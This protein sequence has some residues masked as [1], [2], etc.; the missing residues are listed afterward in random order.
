MNVW[1]L[2]AASNLVKSEEDPHPAEGRR[3]IRV[4]KV[5]V[6]RED[7]ALFCGKRKI[8][9]PLVP[10]RFAVG[11]VADEG[12]SP[13]FPKGARVLLHSR[14]PAEDT[15]AEPRT[16]TE[17]DFLVCGR[18]AD[19]FLRDFVYAREEDLTLLP[20][21]VND[22]KALLLYHLSLAQAAVDALD[23]KR[24]EHIAVIGGN[25]LGF[26]IARLLIYRQAAPILVDSD[27]D[28]L[29]FAR[30]R[31]VYYTS[32]KDDSL[33][34]FMGTVTGGRLA[35]GAVFAADMGEADAE[36]P[37][38]VCAPGRNVVICGSG[39][40]TF[41][42]PAGEI[43]RKQLSVHGV[44]DGTDEL[45]GAVNLIA[46]KAVDL[47]AFRFIGYSADRIPALFCELAAASERPIDEICVIDLV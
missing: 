31:G 47:S 9:Y 13:L 40:E 1:K 16:F 20:D 3:R 18:T 15:G 24:G 27:K 11:V 35:D 8:K 5:F 4:T 41:S 43:V 42:L 30:A 45:E 6:T 37:F 7:G 36:L 21:A 10:G 17:D 12:A 46:N 28:R 25:V 26:F 33:M 39:G 19:G 38:E 23:A 34:S 29:E 14:I 44:A 2:T 22:E 32:P